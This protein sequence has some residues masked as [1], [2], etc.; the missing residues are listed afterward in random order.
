MPTEVT[1]NDLERQRVRIKVNGKLDGP[2]VWTVLSG[3][4]TVAPEA[5]GM[6]AWL[7]SED[8]VP[9]DGPFDTLYEA[10]PL[11]N[12][13]PVPGDYQ[14]LLHVTNNPASAGGIEVGEVELK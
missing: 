12:G 6:S 3:N 11:A 7:V 2:P 4:G 1:C 10:H 14:V 5:D 13:A 8:N 9:G